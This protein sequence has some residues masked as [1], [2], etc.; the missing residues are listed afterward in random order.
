MTS[1]DEAAVWVLSGQQDPTADLVVR[2]LAQRGVPVFRFNTADFPTTLVMA[3]ELRDKGWS[4]TVRAPC[5]AGALDSVRSVYYRRPE[6]FRIDGDLPAGAQEFALGQSRAGLLGVLGASPALWVNHPAREGEANYKPWQL[7]VAQ[8]AGLDP[9]RTLITNEPD[10]ARHFVKTAPGPVITKSLVGGVLVDGQRRGAATTVVDAGELDDSIGLCA[11]L[12]QDWVEKA[13]EVRL[14][15]VGDCF[16]AVEI[17]AGSE[18]ARIDW[19]SDYPSLTYCVT[20][21]P[22]AVR[23]GVVQLM[24]HFGLAYGAFDFVVTPTGEWRFLEI[25]ANGQWGWLEA[26][27]GLPIAAALADL[28]ERGTSK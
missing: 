25:N 1:T 28:L 9:P 17:H 7:A 26:E 5:R 19:R 27:T 11:H 6:E 23:D 14:T 24:R 4:G 22:P 20:E 21:A 2:E 8:W 18:A 3:A 15:V 10:A 16:F 13:H 12:F